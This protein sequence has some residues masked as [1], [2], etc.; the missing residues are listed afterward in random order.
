MPPNNQSLEI[1]TIVL[2]V[3]SITFPILFGFIIWK[4][5]KIFVTRESFDD[6]K[7]L[8]DTQRAAL[9]DSNI[10]IEKKLDLLVEA[11][12]NGRSHAR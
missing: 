2:S 11:Q 5:M 1:V 10:R 9:V 6:Y 12:M 3:G 4:M 8:A 7:K